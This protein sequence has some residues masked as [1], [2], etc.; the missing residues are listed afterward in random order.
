MKI[1]TFD[2]FSNA[3]DNCFGWRKKEILNCRVLI[4]TKGG[5]PDKT[6]LRAGIPLL[7]A[8]WEGAIKES[9][10]LLL[11]FINSQKIEL[12]SLKTCFIYLAIT[13]HISEILE[14][15]QSHVANSAI[16]LLTNR[17]NEKA[18][19]QID[20]AIKT[21]S[22]LNS[23]L[24]ENI[25]NTIGID[26]TK[27]KHYSNLIDLHLLK[28]RNEI[29]HGENKQISQGDFMELSSKVL[30]ILNLFKTDL[31]NTAFTKSYLKE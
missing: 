25:T 14:T 11:S 2:D 18:F 8:H 30:D 5:L 24:F 10:K 9:S 31:E 4:A 12:K 27:Y 29:S 20:G 1:R 26:H 6:L 3:L 17:L 22:N 28:K 21:D 13:R 16:D 19:L 23:D 15:K 7:Y